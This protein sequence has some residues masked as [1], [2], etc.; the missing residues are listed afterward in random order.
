ME[1]KGCPVPVK[2]APAAKDEAVAKR[3]WAESER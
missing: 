3:L 2:I 1:L